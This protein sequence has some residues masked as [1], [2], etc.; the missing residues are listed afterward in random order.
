MFAV[1]KKERKKCFLTHYTATKNSFTLLEII[2]G[3]EKI[4][5]LP[6]QGILIIP[7][8]LTKYFIF[9]LKYLYLSNFD[10]IRSQIQNTAIFY[11]IYVNTVLHLPSYP[12]WYLPIA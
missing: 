3:Q 5:G 6:V 9:F 2:T 7:G 8:H 4:H 11:S 10:T 12:Y 1:N